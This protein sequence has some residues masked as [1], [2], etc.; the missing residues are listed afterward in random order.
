[1]KTPRL[2]VL[3]ALALI[4]VAAVDSAFAITPVSGPAYTYMFT[5]DST[6]PDQSYNGSTITIKDLNIIN[7]HLFTIGVDYT[8]GNSTWAPSPVDF[9]D[10]NTWAGDFSIFGSIGSFVGDATGGSPDPGNLDFFPNTSA[11]P[12]GIWTPVARGVPDSGSTIALMAISC[13]GLFLG[14]RRFARA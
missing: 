1:M 12:H 8:P 10:A 9:Y 14:Y 7:W 5:A 2:L 6:E 11:D 3:L 13:A 4:V